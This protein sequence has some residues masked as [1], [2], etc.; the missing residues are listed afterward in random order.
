MKE[1]NEAKAGTHGYSGSCAPAAGGAG[2]AAHSYATF[3]VGV[4]EWLRK[5]SGKGIKKSPVK[6][7]VKGPVS[8]PQVVYET[9][10]RVCDELDRGVYQGPK[11]ITCR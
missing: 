8:K 4:F 11:S 3:S 6:V 7:R 1:Q 2:S 9:A 5:S 10:Q